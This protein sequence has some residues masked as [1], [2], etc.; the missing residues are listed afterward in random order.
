MPWRGLC[1]GLCV[2]HALWH[3]VSCDRRGHRGCCGGCCGRCHGPWGVLWEV[4]WEV[5]WQVG[6][7]M[8][9][10]AHALRM[11]FI[12][13]KRRLQSKE[14]FIYMSHHGNVRRFVNDSCANHHPISA[15]SIQ[16]VC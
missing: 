12:D 15:C 11:N 9:M 8:D 16:S 2:W 4:P 5:P 6:S 13:R 10:F 7:F 3:E 1:S 14:L